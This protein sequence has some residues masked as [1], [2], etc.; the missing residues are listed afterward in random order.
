MI[1]RRAVQARAHARG[2][3]A[4][5]QAGVAVAVAAAGLAQGFAVAAVVFEEAGRARLAALADGVVTTAVAFA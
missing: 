2:R 3:V 1:A 5:V 4:Q